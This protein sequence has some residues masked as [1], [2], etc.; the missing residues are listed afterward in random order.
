MK[1]ILYGML[2]ISVLLLSACSS[3]YSPS[4]EEEYIEDDVV[5][6]DSV[7]PDR[8]IIYKAEA[9]IFISDIDESVENIR[10]M[11]EIDEWFDSESISESSGYLVMRV[12]TERLESVIST[13]KDSFDVSNYKKSATDISLEYQSA[14]N[15]IASYEAERAQLVI[16]YTGASLSDMI[17]I[18][19]RIAE[20]D[21][22]LGEL[23]GTLSQ[24][25]SL[26]DYSTITLTLRKDTLI[27]QLPFGTRIIDGLVNGFNALISFFDTLIIVLVTI[28]PWAAV[29]V[30]AG[31][32]IFRLYKHFDLKKPKKKE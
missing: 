1:K 25:D 3:N 31:Y 2:F 32:G 18:N 8:K 22:E 6:L 26:V 9:T 28:L 14:T 15:K 30:P 12:K 21:L 16:L 5:Q 17:T 29:F 19:S 23:E 13:L 4:L 10:L 27:S 11:L 7:P 24:F 20:I